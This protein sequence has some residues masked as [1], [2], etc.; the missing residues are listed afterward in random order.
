M[1]DIRP[2]ENKAPHPEKSEPEKSEPTPNQGSA[3]T[4]NEPSAYLLAFEAMCPPEER[5]ILEAPIAPAPSQSFIPLILIAMAL[6]NG[7]LFQWLLGKTIM[8]PPISSIVLGILVV[9]FVFPALYI[10]SR[11]SQM[12]DARAFVT[13]RRIIIFGPFITR[14]PAA[15]SWRF[16]RGVAIFNNTFRAKIIGARDFQQGPIKLK[17]GSGEYILKRDFSR[18]D[19]DDL[20]STINDTYK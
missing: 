3:F 12:K 19:M 17:L 18:Q 20:I 4:V 11:A 1:V 7:L 14:L 9:F 8:L 13:N 15:G 5:L 6:V 10:A 16:G 2:D